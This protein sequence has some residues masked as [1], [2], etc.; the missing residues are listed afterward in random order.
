MNIFCQM[1]VSKEQIT[2]L[3]VILDSG[4]RGADD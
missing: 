1:V 4:L 2:D 3:G